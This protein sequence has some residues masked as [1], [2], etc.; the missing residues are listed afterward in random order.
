MRQSVRLGTLR[1]GTVG[2]HWSA[3]V[4]LVLLTEA[5]AVSVLRGHGGRL[6][7]PRVPDRVVRRAQAPAEPVSGGIASG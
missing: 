5:R 3:L 2:L 7:H 1:S 4:I 6:C